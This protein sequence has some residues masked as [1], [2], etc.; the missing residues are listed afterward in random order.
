MLRKALTVTV[1]AVLLSSTAHARDEIRIVGSSTVYPFATA[2]AEVYAENSGNTVPVIESTGSSGGLKLFCAG[3]GSDTPDITNA[4]R[5]IKEKEIAKCAGNGVTDIV[6]LELGYDGVV[7]ANDRSGPDFDLT[8]EQIFRALAKGYGEPAN[9]SDV[10]PSLP[11]LP[12]IVNGP[13]QGSGT[14]DALVELALQA[15]CRAAGHDKKT[16]KGVELRDDGAYVETDENKNVI[17]QELQA[18]PNALAVIGFSFLDNNSDRLK[19]ANIDGIEPTF[20]NIAEGQYS[21]SRSL[22]AY[23]KAGHLK[24]TNGLAEFVLELVSEDAIGEDGYLVER[25]LI[26][27]PEDRLEEVQNSGRDMQSNVGS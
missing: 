6:E 11:A 9:W 18:N 16:C 15:G 10:D 21:I 19:G 26:P 14:R 12:V 17:I 1:A 5:R 24:T 22:Y 3:H 20:E 23:V 25:G 8:P 7:L 2:A 27:L 4:S 13:G